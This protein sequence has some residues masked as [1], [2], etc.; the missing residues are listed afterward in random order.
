MNYEFSDAIKKNLSTKS[1]SGQE[2]NFVKCW[3]EIEVG[4]SIIS[5]LLS[6]RKIVFELKERNFYLVG[7]PFASLDLT[8]FGTL[9]EAWV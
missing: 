1:S 8:I 4:N 5:S 7:F 2:L 9:Y 6:F 3:S